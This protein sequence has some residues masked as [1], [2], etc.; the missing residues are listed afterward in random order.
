MGGPIYSNEGQVQNFMDRA[1]LVGLDFSNDDATPTVNESLEPT[2]FGTANVAD[3]VGEVKR[4]YSSLATDNKNALNR[5]P[6]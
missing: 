2:G 5:S 1:Q 3:R 6:Y 4:S